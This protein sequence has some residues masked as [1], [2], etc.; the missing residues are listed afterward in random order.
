VVLLV[1]NSYAA[2]WR[3]NSNTAISA[4]FTS[5]N[6]A[7]A[8]DNV[9]DGD[10]L[11]L[12]NGSFF[13][14]STIT[15][16]LVVIGPGYFLGEQDSSY[17]NIAP[18]IVQSIDI[19]GSAASGT[20]ITGVRVVSSISVRDA[21]NNVVIERSFT[22]NISQGGGSEVYGLTVR[23]CYIVGIID[24]SVYFKSTSFY[25]NIIIGRVNLTCG[26]S[27]HNFYNN[28]IYFNEESTYYAFY[29][30]NSTVTNNIIIR[31]PATTAYKS[32]GIDFANS[33]NT[34]FSGNVLSQPANASYAQNLYAQTKAG[35][36]ALTGATDEQWK[37]AAASPAKGYGLN[38]DD[39]GAYGGVMKYVPSGFPYLVPR[40]FKATIPSTGTNGTIQVNVKIKTQEE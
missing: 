3:V 11:Y 17:A 36:F 23:Q 34:T 19:L 35:V 1:S 32:Y 2:K 38:G 8:S 5:I 16:R 28:I 40:I 10:T 30:S 9:V 27:A 12:E 29:A 22:G 39:C 37:L 25:N 14:S 33:V 20:T 21:A 26:E 31:E 7:V 15:K 4:N 13:Q 6:D 18:A 24:G